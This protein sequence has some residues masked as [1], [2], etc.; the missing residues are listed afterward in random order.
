MMF[1]RTFF[2]VIGVAG[3]TAVMIDVAMVPGMDPGC[4]LAGIDGHNSSLQPG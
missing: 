3:R 2:V 4:D 1:H